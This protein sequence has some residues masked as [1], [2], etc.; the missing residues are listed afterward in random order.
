MDP[1]GGGRVGSMLVNG[2]DGGRFGPRA[3]RDGDHVRHE[4]GD[5][6]DRCLWGF[7]GHLRSDHGLKLR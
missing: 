6:R 5:S 2:G 1:A 7:L 3:V 4:D